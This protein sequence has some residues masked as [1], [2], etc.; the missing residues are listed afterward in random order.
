VHTEI[1]HEASRSEREEKKLDVPGKKYPIFDPNHRRL[2]LP[3]A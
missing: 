2:I 3:D 1:D